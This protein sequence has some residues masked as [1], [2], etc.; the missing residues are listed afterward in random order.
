MNKRQALWLK[1]V[2]LACMLI[3][4]CGFGFHNWRLN[5]KIKDADARMATLTDYRDAC[6]DGYTRFRDSKTKLLIYGV[7]SNVAGL[8][9]KIDVMLLKQVRP[10]TGEGRKFTEE[11]QRKLQKKAL[12]EL[13]YVAV[14]FAD[15]RKYSTDI[16]ARFDK[17]KTVEE[18]IS[19][20]QEAISKLNHRIQRFQADRK[21]IS[22]LRES[23]I[24]TRDNFYLFYLF[25]QIIGV[26][27]TIASEIP[28]EK[29]DFES[30]AV[31]SGEGASP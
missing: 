11:S 27:L 6:F 14:D 5:N 16:S 4:T 29:I 1:V 3:A 24:N 20:E 28:N 10:Q 17:S 26:V 15:R 8:F 2:G 22:K 9:D 7:A 13:A 12:F 21:N 31:P 23:L 18:R 30:K 25:L 19:L